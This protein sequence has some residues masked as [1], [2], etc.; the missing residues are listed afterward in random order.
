LLDGTE[1]T[2]AV[3]LK[4]G[5]WILKLESYTLLHNVARL[6]TTHSID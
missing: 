5:L 6:C 2:L 1:A 3:I 4:L